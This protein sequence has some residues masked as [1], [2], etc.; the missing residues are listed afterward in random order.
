MADSKLLS[1]CHWQSWEEKCITG[2]C[3][4]VGAGPAHKGLGSNACVQGDGLKAPLFLWNI[5]RAEAWT[6]MH[7]LTSVRGLLALWLSPQ[8]LSLVSNEAFKIQSLGYLYLTFPTTPW[9]A[10][11]LEPMV[12]WLSPGVLCSY[13]VLSKLSPPLWLQVSCIL[14]MCTLLP[15]PLPLLER[16]WFRQIEPWYHHELMFLPPH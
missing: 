12:G 15:S 14:A 1:G 3:K 5:L 9:L 10:S 6:E 7:S 13:S 11:S 16:T 8:H 4:K 2:S